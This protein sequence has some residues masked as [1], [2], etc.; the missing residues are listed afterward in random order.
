[1]LDEEPSK[2][3]EPVKKHNPRETVPGMNNSTRVDDATTMVTG[4]VSQLVPKVYGKVDVVSGDILGAVMDPGL[5]GVVAD[6]SVKGCR[7]KQ[8]TNDV[9]VMFGGFFNGDQSIAM[10]DQHR[11]KS[12]KGKD[13]II[14]E[15]FYEGADKTMEDIWFVPACVAGVFALAWAFLFKTVGDRVLGGVSAIYGYFTTPPLLLFL[16]WFMP[17]TSVIGD[18]L[19][20]YSRRLEK[21]KFDGFLLFHF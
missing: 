9:L 10:T 19:V 21:G 14:V 8:Y 17:L 1:M 16:L 5:S 11:V 3:E 13:K 15:G 6:H 18:D 12:N 20:G 7:T 2:N 4:K